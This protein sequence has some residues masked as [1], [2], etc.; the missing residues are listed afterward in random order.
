MRPAFHAGRST[1]RPS[2]G[3]QPK[4]TKPAKPLTKEERKRIAE[5]LKKKKLRDDEQAEMFRRI[6]DPE[7]PEILLEERYADVKSTDDF[8]EVEPMGN[9]TVVWMNMNHDF[10]QNVYSKIIEINKI[11]TS[12]TDPEKSNL[13]DIATELKV[14]IDNMII[15]YVTSRN[16][17]TKLE[18]YD[19]E[20]HESLIYHQSIAL[21]KLYQK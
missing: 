12:S 20:T 2:E 18:Q 15:A 19:S 10:F 9:K 6:E 7:S 1:D 4:S 17:L 5:E 8:I 13:I 16:I 3:K 11:G 14:E 21:K